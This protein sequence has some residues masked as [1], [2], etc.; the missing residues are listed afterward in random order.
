MISSARGQGLTLSVPK[1]AEMKK[2][3]FRP[4]AWE[5]VQESAEYLAENASTRIAE[6]FLDAV[7]ELSE[8]LAAI[9]RMGAS[10]HFANPLL[11]GVRRFSVTGFDKWLVFYRATD[12]G[13]EV[14]RVLHGAR[15][16]A[17][18]LGPDA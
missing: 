15:D 11:Q 6:Q 3:V 18:I 8:R 7:V 10:C 17:S 14:I 1:S 12:S 16:I 9:P 2:I 5:D 13:I 4:R